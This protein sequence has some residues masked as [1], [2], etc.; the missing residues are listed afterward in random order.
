MDGDLRKF[1]M[2]AECAIGGSREELSCTITNYNGQGL[3]EQA[4]SLAI[5]SKSISLQL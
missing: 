3:G 4:T 2:K 5:C 1:A